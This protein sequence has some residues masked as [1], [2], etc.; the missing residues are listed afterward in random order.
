MTDFGSSSEVFDVATEY[1][2]PKIATCFL[3]KAV[4]AGVKFTGDEIVN[5]ID[6]VTEEFIP[7]LVM[8]NSVPYTR[9]ELEYVAGYVSDDLLQ[10][11]EG[12]SG[13]EYTN[14]KDFYEAYPSWTPKVF[15]ERVKKLKTFGPS[16]EVFEVSNEFVKPDEVTAFIKQAVAAGVRFTPDEIIEI[17]YAVEQ[18]YVPELV[19]HNASPFTAEALE[20][21]AESLPEDEIEN[22]IDESNIRFSQWEDFYQ[23]DEK[24][25][26]RRAGDITDFGSAEE[27]SEVI[28]C[29]LDKEC[30]TAFTKLALKGGVE[31]PVAEIRELVCCVDS[32]LHRDLMRANS[33][34]YTEDDFDYFYGLVEDKIIK[35]IAK[36]EKVPYTL[37]SEIQIQMPKQKGPGLF[38]AILAGL[39]MASLYDKHANVSHHNGRC[40]GDCAHCP[41]HYGY[42]YGRWYYGHDHVH[43]CEFGGNRGSG[44]M[45]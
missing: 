21:L 33:T 37:P 1:A 28:R 15:S 17:S 14:W 19:K 7:A 11:L 2:D 5:M 43:G 16:D 34:K 18:D 3:K 36:E 30:A 40:N 31:F 29:F 35:Y 8:N 26:V 38:T 41:P 32:S 13:I 27:V 39:G 6:N 4:K 23:W 45:D 42:R 24:T 25:Q 12:A 9:D 10:R 22:V 44:S 20:Y